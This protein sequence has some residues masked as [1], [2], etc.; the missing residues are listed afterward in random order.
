MYQTNQDENQLYEKS[1]IKGTTYIPIKHN[2]NLQ[3]QV[4]QSQA[5]KMASTSNHDDMV[6]I[7]HDYL[8][9]QVMV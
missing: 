5:S 4:L 1:Q 8:T 2:T 3:P 9:I 7:L 6:P